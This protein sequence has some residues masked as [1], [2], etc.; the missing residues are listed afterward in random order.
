MGAPTRRYRLRPA[1]SAGPWTTATG[2]SSPGS[3]DRNRTAISARRGGRRSPDLRASK[4]SRSEYLPC[5]C[6]RLRPALLVDEALEDRGVL[7]F[8]GKDRP[9][10]HVQQDAEPVE[11]RE[12]PEREPHQ[13]HVHPEVTSEPGTDARHD[14]ALPDPDKPFA[15]AGFAFAVFTHAS[16]HAHLAGTLSSGIPRLIP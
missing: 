11:D 14:A 10:G 3:R 7:A 9:G 13:V 16:D 1:A 2:P 15:P 12:H 6:C 4:R 5:C 8:L